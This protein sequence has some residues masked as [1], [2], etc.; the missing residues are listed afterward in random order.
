[1]SVC[2][3]HAVAA[4]VGGVSRTTTDLGLETEVKAAVGIDATSA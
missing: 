2:A 3:L 1:M 4:G